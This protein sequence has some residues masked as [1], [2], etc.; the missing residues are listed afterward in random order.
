MNEIVKYKRSTLK[1]KEEYYERLKESLDNVPQCSSYR[2]F[3]KKI[4]Q[5]GRL[6]LIAEIKKASPSQGL[7]REDFDVLAIAKA[8]AESQADAISVLTEDK[9]FLGQPS[10]VR[11]VA[12]FVRLPVLAKD[13]FID[14]GQ[15][16]EARVLG[17]S[18]VLLIVA[19]LSDNDLKHLMAVANSLDVDCLVEV[20]NEAELRRALKAGADIIGVNNRDLRSFEV[21]FETSKRLVPQIPPDRVIVVESGINCFEDIY[22]I[23]K[24]GANAVL[25]GETFMREQDIGKKV[26]EVMYGPHA[27]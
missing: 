18:A 23:T 17:A 19:I 16:Y 24:L 9:Y 1:A 6:N 11:K 27:S 7:I 2:I 21:D 14:E 8:Y 15:I 3:K 4:S 22:R 10:Y 12:E 13:F 25:I 5:E 20:H 26:K